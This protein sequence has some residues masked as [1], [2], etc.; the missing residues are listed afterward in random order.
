MHICLIK[1]RP[2][3]H[4]STLKSTPKQNK[5][6]QNPTEKSANQKRASERAQRRQ[7]QNFDGP[8]GVCLTTSDY[9]LP[10]IWR[11]P[12]KPPPLWIV[13]KWLDVAA[14]RGW[15]GALF[16]VSRVAE[17]EARLIAYTYHIC[18]D[19]FRMPIYIPSERVFQF[20]AGVCGAQGKALKQAINFLLLSKSTRGLPI[21]KYIPKL[22]GGILVPL[23]F[24]KMQ[25]IP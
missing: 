16:W 9:T 10:R 18:N 2:P 25:N 15:G 20:V 13:N 4:P 7:K 1:P 19:S 24:F 11:W 8:H 6:H 22:F 23:G 3:S 5:K 12:W 21:K 14:P 17:A